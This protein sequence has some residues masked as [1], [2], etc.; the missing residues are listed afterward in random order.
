MKHELFVDT[1]IFL[2]FL[3]NDDPIKAKKAEALFKA[4]VNGKQ[5][6]RTSL[7]VIAEIVWTLESFYELPKEDIANKIAMILNTPHLTCSEAPLIRRALDLYL[8]GSILKP[9][10]FGERKQDPTQAVS[11]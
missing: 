9:I 7:L 5:R 8:P 2:R 3:T 6:L 10:T 1:N 11:I 4:A